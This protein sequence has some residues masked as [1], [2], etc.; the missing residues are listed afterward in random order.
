VPIFL[1]HDVHSITHPTLAQNWT[2]GES[3][4]VLPAMCA[5]VCCEPTAAYCLLR[6]ATS[7]RL[8]ICINGRGHAGRGN[9]VLAEGGIV[10]SK[11]TDKELLELVDKE[12][13]KQEKLFA[14]TDD[15]KTETAG[16]RKE[17]RR[18]EPEA[19]S[20]GYADDQEK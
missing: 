2:F 11:V 3:C 18:I 20:T 16:K 13:A 19:G 5:Q 15:M 8:F 17:T 4:G 12:V 6:F 10:G 7:L 14:E 9:Y 1:L